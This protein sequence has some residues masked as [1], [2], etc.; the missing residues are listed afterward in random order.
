MIF[1]VLF[2]GLAG[3]V[4]WVVSGS[5]RDGAYLLPISSASRHFVMIRD[6]HVEDF[7]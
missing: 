3:W 7:S 5:K 1:V 4:R 6:G 2:A